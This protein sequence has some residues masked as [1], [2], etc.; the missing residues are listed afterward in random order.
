MGEVPNMYSNLIDQTQFILK[1]IN[2]IKDYVIAETRKRE[3]LSK[4]L[5]KY[6]AAFDCFH[7]ELNFLSAIKGAMYIAYFANVISAHLGITSGSFVL[8]SL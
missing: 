8:R 7:K 1:K 3:T 2:K 5:N 4:G 6:T